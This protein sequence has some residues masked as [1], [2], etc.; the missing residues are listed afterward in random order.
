M[1][2]LSLCETINDITPTSTQREE[3]KTENEILSNEIL[4][5]YKLDDKE[6]YISWIA[7]IIAGFVDMFWVTDVRLLKKASIGLKDS[8]MKLGE[9]GRVNKWIDSRI[10]NFYSPDEIKQLARKFKVPYDVSTT[11]ADNNVLGL[12][13]RTHRLMSLGHDPILGFFFG[14]RDIMRNTFTVI[15]NN[16]DTQVIKREITE[17]VAVSLFKAIG[18]QLGHLKS[19]LS[20]PA[21]LPIPFFGLLQKLKE[22]SPINEMSYNRLVKFMY[23]KGYNLNHFIAM[24]VPG[25]CIEIINRLFFFCYNLYKG[26]TF[27]DAIPVNNEKIDKMMLNSYAIA[28]SFNAGKIAISHGNIFAINPVLWKNTIIYGLK[29]LYYSYKCVAENKRHEHIMNVYNLNNEKLD[30]EIQ[31]LEEFKI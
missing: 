13:G 11:S 6:L 10:K 20:T 28:T 31:Q 3:S 24:G 22:K 9:S 30:R 25:M 14:V 23:I 4:D 1:D 2:E 21:G 26:K 7:G 17:K 27:M 19:D 15:D 12:G 18:I 8:N 16:G 29:D 5:N